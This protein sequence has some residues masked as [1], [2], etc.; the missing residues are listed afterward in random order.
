MSNDAINQ[1]QN[2][3]ITRYASPQMSQ[4]W[5]PQKKFSTWRR[6]WVALAESE[7]E[8]GLPITAEQINQL[9]AHIGQQSGLPAE[10]KGRSSLYAC[11]TFFQCAL[12][13]FGCVDEDLLDTRQ[14]LQGHFAARRGVGRNFAPAGNLEPRLADG[15]FD[16]R[17]RGRRDRLVVAQEHGAGGEPRRERE[18]ELLADLAQETERELDQEAA[19]VAGLAVR[20]DGTTMRQAGQ[21]RN[22]GPYDEMTGQVIEIGDQPET[23]AVTLERRV[24]K[25]CCISL[26]RSLRHSRPGN[27]AARPPLLNFH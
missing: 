4:I 9:K 12:H 18:P 8:L 17:A 26:Y 15:R 23:A 2:P 24:V 10:R 14:G 3:L 21:R 5:S 22:R 1:Y 19:T 6:L 16:H 13:A 7:A 27:C 25:P 20:T 11:S